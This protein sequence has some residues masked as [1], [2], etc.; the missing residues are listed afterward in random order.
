MNISFELDVSII[1]YGT[2]KTFVACN[3]WLLISFWGAIDY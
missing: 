1:K 2:H 3:N